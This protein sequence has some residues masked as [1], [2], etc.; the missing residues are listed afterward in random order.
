MER[1]I[2]EEMDRYIEAMAVNGGMT[3]EMIYDDYL[4]YETSRE[5]LEETTENE[6]ILTL[7]RNEMNVLISYKIAYNS[8]D[9]LQN[10]DKNFNNVI[11]D[12]CDLISDHYYDGDKKAD[13]SF[14]GEE[15][16]NL[17]YLIG[18][19]DIMKNEFCEEKEIVHELRNHIEDYIK[20]GDEL[21]MSKNFVVEKDGKKYVFEKFI[22][23][24]FYSQNIEKETGIKQAV[25]QEELEVNSKFDLEKGELIMNQ[26]EVN[27]EGLIMPE[28]SIEAAKTQWITIPRSVI[29][30]EFEHKDKND[31]PHT[32]VFVNLPQDENNMESFSIIASQVQSH[33][34]IKELCNIPISEYGI[35]LCHSIKEVAAPMAQSGDIKVGPEYKW[36]RDD[37]INHLT[38]DEAVNKLTSIY[39]N[40]NS[41]ETQYMLVPAEACHVIKGEEAK[42]KGDINVVMPKYLQEH[43]GYNFAESNFIVNKVYHLTDEKM[44]GMRAVQCSPNAKFRVYFNDDRF[45]DVAAKDLAGYNKDDYAKFKEQSKDKEGEKE[46]PNIYKEAIEKANEEIGKDTL[47]EDSAQIVADMAKEGQENSTKENGKSKEKQSSGNDGRD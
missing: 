12:Y 13:I 15:Y 39:K 7:S 27:N 26:N 43:N 9:F 46:E 11:S 47:K 2:D 1:N 16:N 38:Q 20:R 31:K 32:Y 30:K 45:L 44:K 23:A 35:N 42:H 36:K 14:Y 3:D 4:K 41:K 6:L 28:T 25:K 22:E 21:S 33:P 18:L 40:I 17:K 10:N 29:G 19:L 5:E 37:E 24:L 8:N 34:F